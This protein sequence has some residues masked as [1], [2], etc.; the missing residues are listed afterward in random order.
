MAGCCITSQ[1]MHLFRPP[2]CCFLLKFEREA[3]TGNKLKVNRRNTT[4]INAL[5][6]S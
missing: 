3:K 2:P 5:S 6:R 4:S 1:A